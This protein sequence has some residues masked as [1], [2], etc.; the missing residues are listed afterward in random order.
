M[1]SDKELIEKCLES[2]LVHQKA[3]Y[4]RFSDMAMGVCMRYAKNR[5]DAEDILQDAF[6]TVFRKLDQYSGKGELGGWIRKI[7]VNTA[8]THF[9]KNKKH[10]LY[11]ALEASGIE[12][13]SF[14]DVFAD[15]SAQ[16]LM[17]KIRKLPENYRV[18]FNLYGIE[19]FT[20]PE[21]AQQ[22]G[23]SVNTS[24]SQYSRAR[25]MLIKSIE[26]DEE[27]ANYSIKARL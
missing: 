11:V 22:L 2:S 4:H 7:T 26:E 17:Q 1:I 15:L 27:T 13:E 23:I 20:H 18:V 3:L 5:K 24:K 16:H 25:K 19:G 8:I 21:I 6:V 14:D 10:H 9:R 12:V